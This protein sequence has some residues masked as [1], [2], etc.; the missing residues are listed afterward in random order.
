MDPIWAATYHSS[1]SR[2]MY[3]K[4]PFIQWSSRG[5]LLDIGRNTLW[6][7]NESIEFQIQGEKRKKKT[8]MF[9]KVLTWDSVYSML[10]KARQ[11]IYKLFY[12]I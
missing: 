3:G 6:P 9:R 2:S 8:E 1:T 10:R 4:L 7:K 12:F 5:Q 11:H